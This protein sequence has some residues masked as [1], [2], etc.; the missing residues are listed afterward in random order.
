M[1]SPVTRRGRSVS[2][3]ACSNWDLENKWSSGNHDILTAV[4]PHL[5]LIIMLVSFL[6]LSNSALSSDLQLEMFLTLSSSW[7][8]TC[9]WLATV[10]RSR[11][12]ISLRASP[13]ILSDCW[14]DWS[15]LQRWSE[16]IWHQVQRSRTCYSGR[17]WSWPTQPEKTYCNLQNWFEAPR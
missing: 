2:L 4:L 6:F 3:T 9:L 15:E 14:R 11:S 1:Q 12:A 7:V 10:L 8:S 13:R 16:M 17:H 5:V